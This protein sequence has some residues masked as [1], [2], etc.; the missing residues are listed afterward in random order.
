MEYC[1]NV[2]FDLP[3]AKQKSPGPFPDLGRPRIF[4]TPCLGL[5]QAAMKMSSLKDLTTSA[6]SVLTS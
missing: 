4:S 2:M 1:V 6:S 5:G 3:K